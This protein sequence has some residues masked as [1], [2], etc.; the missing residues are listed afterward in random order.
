MNDQLKYISPAFHLLLVAF[1]SLTLTS[2][3]VGRYFFWNFADINDYKKFPS[4]PIE[5]TSD[6]FSFKEKSVAVDLKIPQIFEEKSGAITFDEFQETHKTVAFMI[7][8]NDSIL[9]EKYYSGYDDSAIIPSFSLSKSFISALIG[10]AINE[11]LIKNVQ[12]PVTDFIPEL[13]QNDPRFENITLEHLLNMRSGIRFNE[14]YSNPFADMAKYYYG[15]NLNKYLTQLKIETP[16][17]EKYNYLS[18]NT[19][20]LGIAIERA[21]G[22]KLNQY[23]EEKIWK[24]LNMEFD[25]SWSIDSKKDK[26]IKAFCCINARTRDFAKF[27]RLYLNNGKYS[28]QQ[29]IPEEWIKKT[30]AIT[31]DS[32]DSQNY[33][34][35][36]SWRVKED[37][38]IFA[39]GV[40]GQFIY[41][42]PEKN[43]IIVRLGKKTDGINWPEFMEQICTG[44]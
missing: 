2:C 30:M 14:G 13:K 36:Y 22:K 34:Y 20:L 12:Q 16:P 5:K 8:R 26:Q 21:T 40:L 18:V 43:I 11:E 33:A 35:N 42:F 44:L 10:I 32:K 4:L 24:P 23:L 38:A 17:D 29:I 31:N 28:E 37:G 6:E 41:V 9:Y 1:I 7:I 25:A 19:L 27:G 39:K 15:R 3:H